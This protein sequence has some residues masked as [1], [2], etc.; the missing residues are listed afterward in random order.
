MYT[1]RGLKRVGSLAFKVLRWKKQRSE[2]L[3]VWAFGGR[4]GSKASLRDK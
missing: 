2:L 1:M 3:D 4:T